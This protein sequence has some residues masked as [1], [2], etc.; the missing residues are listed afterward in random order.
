M[1]AKCSQIREALIDY[2]SDAVQIELGSGSFAFKNRLK[3]QTFRSD[4]L[5]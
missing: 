4:I 5:N 2:C 3:L 1:I